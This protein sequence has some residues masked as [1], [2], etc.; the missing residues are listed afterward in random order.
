[1][2]RAN[3]F[4]RWGSLISPAAREV[5]QLALLP[6]II[7]FVMLWQ[8]LLGIGILA[9]TDIVT[10]DPLLGG[11]PPGQ[12]PYPIPENPVLRDPVDVFIPWK[13][14]MKSE[15]A[16]GRFPLWNPYNVLGTHF[17][18]NLQSQIFSPFNLLW[19][20]LPPLWGFAAIA[21]L[22]LTL[23]GLGMGLFL[24]RLGLGMAPAIFGSVALPLSGPT[25]AWLQWPITEGLMW[26]PW[27]L[28]AVLGWA[29]TRRPLWLAA[30]S[31]LVAAEMLAG[32][33]ETSFH[34]LAFISIFAL[35]AWGSSTL[36]G[37]PWLLMLAGLMAAGLLGIAISAVQLLPFLD[38]LTA[39]F[40]WSVRAGA[41]SQNIGLDPLAGLMWLTPNGFGWPDNYA[42]PFNWIEANPYVG[43][44]TLL[45]AAWG[46]GVA[47]FSRRQLDP[48]TAPLWQRI[49]SALSP[50]KP[51]FWIAVLLITASMSY[52][53][54]PLSTLRELPG[55]STSLNWRLISVAGLCVVVLAAMGLH[56]LLLLRG[57]VLPRPWE[58]MSFL[59]ALLTIFLLPLGVEA[60]TAASLLAAPIYR[61][62]W[63]WWAAL[64][65][66]AS[67]LLILARL[68]G[69]LRPRAFAVLIIG[70]LLLDMARAGWDF[71]P[72]IDRTTFYPP[73]AI[74]EFLAG[75]GPTERVA[76]VGTYAESNRLLYYKIADYRNYDPTLNSR[77]MVYSRWLSPETFRSQNAGYTTHLTLIRPSA[78]MLAAAGIK[79]LVCPVNED[80]NAWQD[81]PER[82]P[83]YKLVLESH[84]FWVWE[85]VYARP[86]AYFAT[87]F[88]L[89][90]DEETIRRRMRALTFDR[91]NEAHVEDF[92]GTFP[93]NVAALHTGT[94]VTPEERDS[95]KLESYA[96]GDM[97]FSLKA[98]N[99][100]LLIVNEGWT[101]SWRASID[102]APAT[103]YRTNYI[104]QGIVVPPGEHRVTLQYDP[105]A[106][107]WGIAISIIAS[108]GWL[109]L[110]AFSV[111]RARRPAETV[112]ADAT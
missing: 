41:Q 69:W 19:L 38:I 40:Q 46:L 18:A 67:T 84:D 63:Q 22:K 56:R 107:K 15:L 14:Y 112:A 79:W 96:P 36:R 109:A 104:L 83:I 59:L 9:P 53:I 106:F 102:N 3:H 78:T 65:F 66:C 92:E 89:A 99:T 23:Y 31:A 61:H 52:G 4:S 43:A 44:S 103:I 50:R 17:H 70:L 48:H 110:V 32:H 7:S 80:P 72:A 71:N 97:T 94:P 45:L 1:M 75:R 105:P 5:L 6:A 81:V 26:V 37:R 57:R 55:F 73:N 95:I 49:L 10:A 21:A 86:Y 88:Q 100:R 35:A 82:A 98:E 2:A 74:T 101:P 29:D 64:L 76:V 87:R 12:V 11:F 13:F 33:I 24:R 62:A 68:H 25:L 42:G 90:H 60:W 108:I 16:A 30:F 39:S 47:I 28:W 77:Y 8:P 111:R 27:L 20:F 51:V 93:E 54:P 91:V 34:S 85:N 58:V